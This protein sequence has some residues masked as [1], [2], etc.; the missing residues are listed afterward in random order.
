MESANSPRAER[1]VAVEVHSVSH[2]Y[3]SSSGEVLDV[4]DE[5]NFKVDTGEFVALVGPSGC[6]KTTLLNMIAGLL[7]P[8]G[9]YIE[10]LGERLDRPHPASA[11]MFAR[12]CL[13]PWRTA[14]GNV[15]FGLE[16][17]GTTK[18]ECRERARAVLKSLGLQEFESVHPYR[19]SQGMRQR[20][21][22]ARTL[23]LEPELILLD[24]PFAA[25][26]AQTRTAIQAE[27]A[28]V[29]QALGRTVILITHDINE[30]VMLADRVVIM[31]PRPGRIVTV[32]TIPLDRPRDLRSLSF[33]SEAQ[34]LSHELQEEMAKGA[35]TGN[36]WVTGTG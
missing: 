34:T 13:L 27:Y 7:S 11:M 25:L 29:W 4:L 33:R 5:V 15:E 21:A 30:A 18:R 17:R 35:G 6:G 8:E 19:L 31:A 20:V 14:L 12:D 32:R 9:G 22:M 24:E 23:A 10:V 36:G 28:D 2:R 26:D 16:V 3:V 1:E